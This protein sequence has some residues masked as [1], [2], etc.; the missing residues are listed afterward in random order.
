MGVEKE[1]IV[2]QYEEKLM[3]ASVYREEKKVFLRENDDTE[4]GR[5]QQ[6]LMDKKKA[7]SLVVV[8]QELNRYRCQTYR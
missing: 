2:D 7:F 4:K 8:D 1:N 3:Q 5:S 6:C